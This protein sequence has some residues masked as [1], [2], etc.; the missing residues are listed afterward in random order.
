MKR[1]GST[2]DGLSFRVLLGK[3][4]RIQQKDQLAASCSTLRS[5][6]RRLGI[7]FSSSAALLLLLS[8]CGDGGLDETSTD[9]DESITSSD[10]YAQKK[11]STI[12]KKSDCTDNKK[13]QYCGWFGKNLKCKQ[14][15]GT[16]EKSKDCPIGGRCKWRVNRKE[17]TRKCK[18]VNERSECKRRKDCQKGNN[19]GCVNCKK[20]NSCANK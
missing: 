3:I 17:C 12:S 13:Y 9:F 6:N 4:C 2:K 8:A 14:K 5:L 11:C 16:F 19:G 20:G 7:V 18:Y 15:C 10:A 1:F